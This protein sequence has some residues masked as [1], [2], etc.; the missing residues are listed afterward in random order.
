MSQEPWELWLAPTHPFSGSRPPRGDTR[1][2]LLGFP[3]D[4][5]GSFLPGT[6]LAPDQ[7]RRVSQSLEWYSYALEKPLPEN[8]VY[9][10]GDLP[11]VPGRVEESLHRLS[12]VLQALV[13]EGRLPIVL[14][15]EHTLT[16][17]VLPLLETRP[18]AGMVVFDAHGDLRDEYLGSRL[19]H[20]T[21]MRRLL[22]HIEG[23]RIVFVGTRALSEEEHSYARQ[24]GL[25]L[26][27]ARHV[28][29][30]GLRGA[31]LALLRA[32]RD[33][34]PLYISID[35]DVLDPAYA[36]GVGTPEPLG[37]T[38]HQLLSLLHPLLAEHEL[39]ALDIVEHNP[40]AD[41]G[42][43]TSALV[44]K[45]VIEVAGILWEKNR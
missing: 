43:A 2:S 33:L 6:R 4:E 25:T 35:V 14:G 39:L 42:Y 40:L 8:L 18:R 22:D 36:P 41:A 5:T 3:L 1:I 19:N 15:G 23:E 20:A 44:A 10:E 12:S 21:V 31:R 9:D 38:P 45:L 16:R 26:I 32:L 29:D 24:M 11:P 34:D 17:S 30:L 7:V 37:L 27:T 13:A 28:M